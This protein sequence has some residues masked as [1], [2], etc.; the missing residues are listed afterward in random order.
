MFKR[1]FIVLDPVQLDNS[2][3]RKFTGRTFSENNLRLWANG[4]WGTPTDAPL[5]QVARDIKKGGW[6]MFEHIVPMDPEPGTID[7]VEPNPM[8]AIRK[9][10]LKE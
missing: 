8:I 10:L 5:A 4:L 1:Q 9:T 2:M 3:Y 7:P 6:E